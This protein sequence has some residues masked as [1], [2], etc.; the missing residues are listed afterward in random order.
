MKTMMRL[1]RNDGNQK[2]IVRPEGFEPPTLSSVGNR[3]GIDGI[4][5]PGIFDFA[6]VEF[7]RIVEFSHLF[8]SNVPQSFLMED[9]SHVSRKTIPIQAPQRLLLHRDSRITD[10]HKVENHQVPKEA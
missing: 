2:E 4:D 9:E 10:L 7:R 3:S 8:S 6:R 1:G 5:S